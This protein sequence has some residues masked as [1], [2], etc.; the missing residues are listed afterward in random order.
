M[1]GDPRRRLLA[2]PAAKQ[3]SPGNRPAARRRY[4]CG[5]FRRPRDSALRAGDE[6]SVAE[7][8]DAY[9]VRIVGAERVD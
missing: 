4:P 9:A 3:L 6:A 5:R 2:R 7:G 8:T 1:R